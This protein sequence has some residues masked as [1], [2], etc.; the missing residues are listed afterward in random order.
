M[1]WAD[2]AARVGRRP[3]WRVYLYVERCTLTYGSAPCTA[4]GGT[5]EECYNTLATCQDEPNFAQGSRVH[6][7]VSQ[8]SDPGLIGEIPCVIDVDH[9]P[10]E[11]LPGG[12]GT[13]ASVRVTLRDFSGPDRQ[14]PYRDTRVIAAAGT[15]W[16]KFRARSPY[17]LARRLDVEECYR[18]SDGTIESLTRTY[19]VERIDGPDASDKVTI[20]AKDPLKA[21]D[22]DRA[23]APIPS[24]M[25]LT[26][27]GGITAGATTLVLSHLNDP[28]APT[29]Q[30]LGI[31]SLIAINDEIIKLDTKGTAVTGGYEFDATRAQLGTTAAAHAEDDA[32]QY[33][34]AIPRS[35]SGVWVGLA[36]EELLEDYTDVPAA[37]YDSADWSDEQSG[38]SS[39]AVV[40]ARIAEPTPVRTLIRELCEQCQ[41]S[42]WWDEVGRKIR[43]RGETAFSDV[44]GL[45][46][47]DDLIVE[48][49]LDVVEV[50]ELQVTRAACY[51][52]LRDHRKNLD[53]ISNYRRLYA[54]QNAAA[55]APE[56][57]G[58]QRSRRWLSR[59][60]DL[61]DAA[62][63]E[64][65]V[66]RLL[67]RF[68][69]ITPLRLRADLEVASAG[70]EY[71]LG[72]VIDVETR[73]VQGFDGRPVRR[74]F[75]I[76][77][78]WPRDA[79]HRYGL[80]ALSYFPAETATITDLTI[81]ADTS[82]YS[83][84]TALG[85]PAF[86][87][88]VTVTVQAGVT[89]D[90]GPQAGPAFTTQG[91][92]PDSV[93]TVV[94]EGT[95]VG[96]GGSGG[97]FTVLGATKAQATITVQSGQQGGDAIEARCA[98]V[99]ENNG[100]IAGGGGGG[101]ASGDATNAGLPSGD[102]DEPG[103]PGTASGHGGSGGAGGDPGAGGAAV[104]TGGSAGSAGTLTA[105]G[106]GATGPDGGDRGQAGDDGS[107]AVVYEYV[108]PPV[109][110]W[111]LVV[112]RPVSGGAPGRAVTTNGY[113][114]TVSGTG[115]IVGDVV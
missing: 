53:E 86:P 92:H 74:R 58:V 77:K 60:F 81:T 30:T 73:G 4:P 7:F 88:E 115:T 45:V 90:G 23:L 43:L 41:L 14:D 102:V 13:R 65:M 39:S 26:S 15:W 111:G 63:A 6:A 85:G 50:P 103:T 84:A 31:G 33:V 67:D 99:V 79:G 69:A 70:A 16:G 3:F 110:A 37:Y 35:G 87:I 100:T 17:H 104:G 56:R 47:S 105:G 113:T 54:E 57:I 46:L 82:N 9:A 20:V 76:T 97:T 80:E 66:G 52:A 49:S 5:G 78:L 1:T 21:L 28:A 2:E 11:V 94:N 107:V 27:S 40:Y 8:D 68:S 106:T 114:V 112:S 51:Y 95:I 36:I 101:G 38:P 24:Q 72:E 44:A 25:T 71:E 109:D 18:A 59:W 108:E 12:I 32:V 93:V 55:E 34:L 91:L 42:L 10:A 29:L 22:D 98:L 48:G 19:Q 83:V 96:Y 64:L 75:Q 61:G 62:L 89:V